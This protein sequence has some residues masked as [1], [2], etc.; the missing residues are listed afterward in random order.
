MTDTSRM[1]PA[2]QGDR[3]GGPWVELWGD[4]LQRI[5]VPERMLPLS[6]GDV[7]CLYHVHRPHLWGE[8]L[9]SFG[10]QWSGLLL[11]IAM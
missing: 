9:L 7:S 8:P 1:V 4:W 11:V 5:Y 2:I 6:L 10:V 3:T